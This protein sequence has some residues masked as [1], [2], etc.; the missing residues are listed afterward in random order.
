[1]P[2]SSKRLINHKPHNHTKH[3]MNK[4]NLEKVTNAMEFGSPLN[5]VLVMSALDKYC[6]QILAIESKPDNWT[7]GLISWESWQESARDVQ[8]KIK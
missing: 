5:Q 2:I 3:I 6:E 8:E 7:N 1:L 4:T